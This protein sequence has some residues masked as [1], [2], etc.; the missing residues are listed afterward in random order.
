MLILFSNKK[1]LLK[2]TTNNIHITDKGITV[3]KMNTH[4]GFKKVYVIEQANS[5]T[6]LLKGEKKPLI[7]DL[8]KMNKSSI[9]DIKSLVS[10]ETIQISSAIAIVL[11]SSL[12]KIAVNTLFALK[13]SKTDCPCQCFLNFNDAETWLTHQNQE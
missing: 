4:S 10:A 1:K 5:I 11:N 12:K 6:H 3:S 13:G 9:D 7:L 8:T 2:T